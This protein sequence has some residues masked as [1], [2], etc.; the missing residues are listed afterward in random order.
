VIALGVTV[1][2]PRTRLIKGGPEISLMS[3]TSLPFSQRIEDGPTVKFS[4]VWRS[5][6][7]PRSVIVKRPP[8][9]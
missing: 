7:D 2:V 5:A 3:I 9:P 1:I 6:E 8:G 4:A